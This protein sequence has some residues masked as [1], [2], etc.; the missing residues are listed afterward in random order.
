[1][2]EKKIFSLLAFY[3]FMFVFYLGLPTAQAADSGLPNPLG[4]T[5]MTL[6]D[7][8]LRS[9]RYALG[10]VGLCAV[11][12]FIYGGILM[13]TSGGKAE[14]V[15]K[16]KDTLIWAVFGL[17]VILLSYSFLSLVWTLFTNPK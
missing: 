14:Q 1:M 4:N 9:G 5:S 3:F 17:A 2:R 7:V 11:I 12:M 15:Q 13:M 10:F 16:S 8:L 6:T